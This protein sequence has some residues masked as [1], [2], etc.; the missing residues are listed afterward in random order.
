MK[1]FSLCRE[2]E[3]LNSMY[4]NEEKGAGIQRTCW[5]IVTRK[6]VQADVRGIVRARE[7]NLDFIA[8]VE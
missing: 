3:R 4:S 8:I 1:R 6:V 2:D 7:K 5:S